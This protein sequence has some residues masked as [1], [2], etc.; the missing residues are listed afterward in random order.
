MPV[1]PGGF[2]G[3]ADLTSEQQ[4]VVTSWGKGQAV[5]AGAGSGKTTTLV[6]KCEELVK[7]NPEARFAAVSFTEKSASELREKLSERGLIDEDQGRHLVTTIHGLCS[8]VLREF[9]RFADLDG[10]ETVL[11][12]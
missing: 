8:A 10:E 12:E 7:R 1:L 9:P 4:A 3:L 5:L 11:T 2:K 6:I